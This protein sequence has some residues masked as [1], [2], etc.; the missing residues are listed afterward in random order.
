MSEEKYQ[1]QIFINI[2]GKKRPGTLKHY[3]SN[4]Y[5]YQIQVDGSNLLLPARD[6]NELIR[7]KY[8]YIRK[9]GRYSLEV[10]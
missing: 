10:I 9:N 2:N 7:D 5:V 6:V 4:G 3:E 8:R 1:T